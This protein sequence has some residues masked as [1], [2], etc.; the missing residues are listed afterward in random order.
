[1]ERAF[2]SKKISDFLK[3]DNHRI[4]QS[5]LVNDT[6]QTKSEQKGA[7]IKQ[8][9]VLKDELKELDE[10]HII[11]E[12]I[13]PRIGKRIDN[14]ILYKGIV[15]LLEFKV[16]SKDF[17]KSY[18]NQV[19][20]YAADLNSF[21]EESYD[22]LLVP[23]LICTEAENNKNQNYD[24]I[25]ELRENIL[26]VFCCSSKGLA[27]YIKFICK[28]YKRA[29]FS[30]DKWIKSIYKPTP[31]IIEAARALFKNHTVENI[32]RSD[33]VAINLNKTTDAVNRI[34][35]NSN[36]NKRKSICFITGVPGAGKTLAGLNIADKR[37]N[38]DIGEHAVFLSGNGPLVSVLQEALARDS[39]ERDKEIFEAKMNEL[40]KEI[41]KNS[42][43]KSE[44]DIKEEIKNKINEEKKKK[45]T[46]ADFYREIT[47]FIQNIHKF[48]SDGMNINDDPNKDAP[49]EKTV[50]FDE[51]QRTWDEAQ[52]S[53]FLK[54]MDYSLYEDEDL[55]EN[56]D[57]FSD[58]K[59]KEDISEAE[60]LINIMDRHKDWASIVCLVGGGQEINTGESQGIYGWFKAIK[61]KFSEWD[62]YAS[63]KIR[64]EIY[65]KGNDI[66]AMIKV[67]NCHIDEDLHLSVPL[68]SFRSEKVATFVKE[69]LD[70]DKENAKKLYKEFRDKYPICITRDIESAKK[71]I[72][73]KALGTQRYGLT[74]SSGAKRLRKYGIWVENKVDASKWFLND[75]DD[76][77]SSYFLEETA[78]EFDI[79]GLELDWSIVAWDADFRFINDKFELKKFKGTKWQDVN[80]EENALYLKNAYRVLLTRARQGLIIFVPK[81]DEN[82]ITMKPEFYDGTYEY[83]KELGLEEI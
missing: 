51:A 3:E 63:S 15:F 38:A 19:I 1:M 6:S 76:V 27:D 5:I 74:A 28:K 18:K 14:V 61:E 11:F 22:K 20:D 72:K 49:S 39:V 68:R 81:G 69:L 79:Q 57:S 71:W 65:S 35:E 24:D 48:R 21:H 33:S 50:I 59:P 13:V 41:R 30:A 31:T 80:S 67:L 37:Q 9:K 55:Y 56:E 60:F 66:D 77:R 17:L 2:Y 25:N 34:I 73:K 42:K 44:R 10:G 52:L 47:C 12:Y 70:V 4:N 46:K 53:K 64:D 40:E 58:K 43:N 8:I 75:E 82:D 16:G 26:D 54:R 7:W 23:I 36:A 29:S 32:S 83:L 45:K 78:T 62:V